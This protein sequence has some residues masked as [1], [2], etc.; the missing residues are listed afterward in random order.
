M[1]TGAGDTARHNEMLPVPAV[2]PKAGCFSRREGAGLADDL[3]EPAKTY[4]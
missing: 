3:L 1:T 2:A 4:A